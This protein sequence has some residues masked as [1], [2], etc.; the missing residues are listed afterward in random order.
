MVRSSPLEEGLST[1]SSDEARERK[2]L[3][4][5]IATQVNNMIPP[6]MKELYAN[7]SKQV[8]HPY[9]IEYNKTQ[10]RF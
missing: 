3:K 6:S 10:I 1:A 2:D 5:A 4:D 8:S 9:F 7:T